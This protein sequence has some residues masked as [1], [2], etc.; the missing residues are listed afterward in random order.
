M[1]QIIDVEGQQ[2]SDFMALRVDGLEAGAERMID[3]T[4]TRTMVRRS[5]PGPGLLDKFFD[6]DMRPR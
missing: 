1:V 3:A 4:A 6:R 2:C 5:Y